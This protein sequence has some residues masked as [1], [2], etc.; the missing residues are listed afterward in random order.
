MLEME[1]YNSLEVRET[2]EGITMRWQELMYRAEERMK[3][4]M[5][6]CTW[7]KTAEQVREIG[8]VWI[9][10]GAFVLSLQ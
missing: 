7:F 9:F 10:G 5:S 3:L 6:S 4:V 1:H 2:A 8:L